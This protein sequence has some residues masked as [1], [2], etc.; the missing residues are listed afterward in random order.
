MKPRLLILDE[1][2]TFLD[3]AAVERLVGVLDSSP[4]PLLVV[5]HDHDFLYRVTK[6]RVRLKDGA[7]EE[8]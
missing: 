5:S 6:T 2:T 1:P 7:I 8:M 3:E 4:L